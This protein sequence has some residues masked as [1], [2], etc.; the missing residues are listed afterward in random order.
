MGRRGNELMA[1]SSTIS[2]TVAMHGACHL[3][4]VD[5]DCYNLEL[6]DDRTF[7]GDRASKSAFRAIIDTQKAP[8]GREFFFLDAEATIRIDKGAMN[9]GA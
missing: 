2:P 1:D 3:H 4:T 7:L 9:T 8:P 6:K 5:V